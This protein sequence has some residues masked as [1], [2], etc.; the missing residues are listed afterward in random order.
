M[1][2][3]IVATSVKTPS[4]PVTRNVLTMASFVQIYEEPTLR[5]AYGPAYDEF[6]ENVPRWLP[7][8]TTW[9]QTSPA[10]R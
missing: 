4:S 5:E 2:S 6:C 3:S 10:H 9:S 7:R 1:A 8:L